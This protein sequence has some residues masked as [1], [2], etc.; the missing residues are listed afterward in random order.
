[1]VDEVGVDV[2]VEVLYTK[3]LLDLL[4]TALRWGYLLLL[5]VH[6][7]VFAA[8]QARH[9]GRESVVDV[10]GGLGHTRDDERGARLVDQDGVDLVHYPEA[11]LALHELVGRGRYIV[12]EVV[13]AELGVRAVGDVRVVGDL[14]LVEVHALLDEADLESQESVDLTHP[15]RVAAGQVVVDGDDVDAFA[16]QGVEV[17]G[18]GGRERL[19]LARLHLRYLAFVQHY[20][21]HDLLVEGAHPKGTPGDLPHDGESL[22]QQIIEGLAASEPLAKLVRLLPQF[23]VGEILYLGLQ[24]RDRLYTLLEDLDLATFAYPQYL[25]Q[26]VRQNK[27]PRSSGRTG[28][29]GRLYEPVVSVTTPVY[30]IY[31]TGIGTREHVEVV[32]EELQLQD[33]LLSAHR[34]HLELLGP[35]YARLDLLFFLYDE[36]FRLVGDHIR[37]ILQLA[38]PAVDLA[39]PEALDLPLELVRHPVYGGVHVFGGLTGFQHRSVDKQRGLSYLRLGDGPV[40]LVDELYLGT[41]CGALVVEET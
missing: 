8:L 25:R 4:D 22:G 18:H 30:H 20:A 32:V 12:P 17:N 10:G 31:I 15:G 7:V 13:E 11:E 3:S 33:G 14:P 1:M 37:R 28:L 34:L 40:S 2:V 6:L 23:R 24:R 29:T 27:L 5:L 16:Y 39:P 9:Y 19:A 21:A 38:L 35:D 41:R 36:G 26:Q